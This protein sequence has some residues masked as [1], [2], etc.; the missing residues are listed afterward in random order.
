MTCTLPGPLGSGASFTLTVSVK[1]MAAGAAVN[2]ASVGSAVG[3]PDLTNNTTSVTTTILS[4]SNGVRFFTVTSTNNQNFLEWINPSGANFGTTVINAKVGSCP[5]AINDAT[6]TVIVP[7]TGGAGLT[8]SFAHTSAFPGLPATNGTTFCYAAWVNLLP[9]GVAGPRYVKGRPFDHTAATTRVRWAFS[10]GATSVVSPGIGP[11][12]HM[13]SNDDSLYAAT[14]GNGGGIWPAGWTPLAMMGPSQGRPSTININVLGATRVIFLGS[15]DTNVRAIDADSGFPKWA[16]SLGAA[17]PVQAGPSGWFS[18]F[19]PPAGLDY[20]LVGTRNTSGDN[21]FVALNATTGVAAWPAFAGVGA[22]KIGI[23]NGQA[24]V[25]YASQRLYFTSHQRAAGNS[26]VWCLSLATGTRI[27]S[28]NLG[29]IAGAPTLRGGKLYV[30]TNAG[31][32]V[33]LDDATNGTTLWTYPTGD[34]IAKGFVFLD[35]FSNQV[36][37]STNNFVWSVPFGAAAGTF[38]FKQPILGPSVPL[39]S[40]A[41]GRV[42]VGSSDGNLYALDSATGLPVAA[43]TFALG[44]GSAAIGG[45]S[46]DVVGNFLY[47]GS[48][49]GVIYA[50]ELP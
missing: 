24:V 4:P 16:T 28:K 42:W 35:R 47:S 29:D 2:Q 32:I 21:S 9:T 30:P 36:Y 3:D 48:E 18:A 45:P 5:I 8:L 38:T 33:A 25:D 10:T 31:T 22:D 1:A 34:G 6:A 44:D 50:V 46:L 12:I 17:N 14:K 41:K 27:W 39:F 11:S 23:I 40:A 43:E 37:F 19:G 7:P 15:Q 26:T 49:A 13:V 20:I